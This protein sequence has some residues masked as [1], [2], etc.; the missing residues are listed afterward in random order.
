[1]DAGLMPDAIPLRSIFRRLPACDV[2]AGRQPDIQVNVVCDAHTVRLPATV[3]SRILLAARSIFCGAREITFSRCRWRF[4][5][6]NPN[7]T[8]R[9]FG[10]MAIINNI[11]MLE[12][13][14]DRS[15]LIREL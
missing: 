6:F 8:R 12:E 1:M 7:L 15:A 11:T 4:D 5:A 14:P 10:V 3:I 9:G 2:L 13:V